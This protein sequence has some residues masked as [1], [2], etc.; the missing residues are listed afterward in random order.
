MANKFFAFSCFSLLFVL[1]STEL[2]FNKDEFETSY[3]LKNGRKLIKDALKVKPIIKKAKNVIIFVGDGMGISTVSAARILKGQM[4]GMSGVEE[5]FSFE[6]FPNRALIKT[7]NVDRLVP[8]SAGTATAFLCGVKA[9]YESLKVNGKIK[10]GDTDC[11][12]IEANA[13]KSIMD[14]ANSARKSTGVVTTTR[15]THATPAASYASISTRYWESDSDLPANLSAKCKDIAK[16]LIENEP[17]NKFKVIMGGGR[18]NFQ[19]QPKGVRKDGL[20]LLQKWIDTRKNELLTDSEYQYITTKQELKQL[21]VNRVKYTLGLFNDDHINY[22]KNRTEEEPSLAEMTEAAIR[23]LKKDEN[24]FVLLVESGRIDSA[25]H[26]NLA[27]MALHDT[28]AL[29]DA[30]SKAINLT[31]FDDTLIIVTADHSHSFS[32]NGY[33]KRGTSLFGHDNE[34]GDRK[35]PYTVLMYTSG[36]GHKAVRDN[37]LLVNT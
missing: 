35:Y 16:Q 33:P 21:D 37:P 14:W 7:Y 12:A 10:S 27:A 8:D 3:W 28:I 25:H 31:S 23:M 4:K 29:D 20:N 5:S 11:E 2:K 18:K 22:D 1:V 26:L 13:V 15:I 32:V 19:Q 17:G 36:P 30:V 6:Q 24:G 9:S 34:P